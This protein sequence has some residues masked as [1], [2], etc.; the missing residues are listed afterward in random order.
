MEKYKLIGRCDLSTVTVR[1]DRTARAK[2]NNNSICACLTALSHI[3]AGVYV[4]L[5]KRSHLTEAEG[6]LDTLTE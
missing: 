1:A 4:Q 5:K 3:P 6:N 2:S